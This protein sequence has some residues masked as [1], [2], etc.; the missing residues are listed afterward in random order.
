MTQIYHQPGNP[1]R[2]FTPLLFAC[3][4]SLLLL[5]GLYALPWSTRLDVGSGRAMMATGLFPNEHNGNLSYA[6]S[7]GD[8]ALSLPEVGGGRFIAAF[9]MGGP[10]AATPVAATL[11]THAQQLTLGAAGPL[12]TYYVL[13]SSGLSGGLTLQIQSATAQVGSDWRELGVLID[14]VELRPLGL[15]ILPAQLLPGVPVILACAYVV[16]GG[17]QA[18][19]RLKTGVLLLLG[20]LIAVSLAVVRGE[21]PLLPIWLSGALLAV[22]VLGLVRWSDQGW[23]RPL[24]AIAALFVVWRLALG[25]VAA[26][27]IWYN[28]ILYPLETAV[29]WRGDLEQPAT[30]GWNLLTTTWIQWDSNQYQSIARTGYAWAGQRFPNMAFFPLYPLLIRLF[31][32]LTLGNTE[33][34]ALLVSHAAFFTALVL[35]YDLVARDCN[36]AI[37]YR[38]IALLL[39]FP[40]SFFFIAGYS[41]SLALLLIVLALWAIQRER[42]WLAGSAGFFLALTRLPGVMITPV[43]GVIYLRRQRWRLASLRG[44]ALAMLLPPL[45]LAVFMGFQ[46]WRFGTPFAFLLAQQAWKNHLTAPWTMPMALIDALFTGNYAGLRFVQLGVWIG[47]LGLTLVAL[48]RLPLAYGLTALLLLAPAYLSSWYESLPRHVLVVFPAFIAL[49]LVVRRPWLRAAL[50]ATM[51][52]LLAIG[53]L[54]YLNARWVA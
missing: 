26:T 43:L 16:L 46:W 44:P 22:A 6:Y 37:A 28:P 11:R 36:P 20:T 25:V 13:A 45:G 4:W 50:L 49:A 23:T 33:V 9:R 1:R 17:L 7:R 18:R 34:A 40:T 5:L 8:A 51:L 52:A 38:T 42:W 12:R 48:R 27:G 54:L 32:P 53:M 24:R 30:F 29:T 19:E 39:V 21:F 35:G 2:S 10:S 41:E 47:F 3:A 14:A 31:S 15:R